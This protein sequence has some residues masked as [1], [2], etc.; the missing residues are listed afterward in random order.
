MTTRRERRSAAFWF[1]ITPALLITSVGAAMGLAALVRGLSSDAPM[2]IGIGIVLL[3]VSTYY[4]V[5]VLRGPYPRR[6]NGSSSQ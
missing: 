6:P 1:S 2:G 5:R 3:P 4:M